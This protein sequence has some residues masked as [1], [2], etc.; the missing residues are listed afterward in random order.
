MCKQLESTFII[1]KGKGY[2]FPRNKEVVLQMLNLLVT[3]VLAQMMC[4]ERIMTNSPFLIVRF[5]SQ[6]REFVYPGVQKNSNHNR[7]LH[8][9]TTIFLAAS[10]LTF[11]YST[12]NIEL[13]HFFF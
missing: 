9:T 5:S 8:G 3:S 11:V 4:S 2:K 1:T 10:S 6:A 7:L 13:R 12:E